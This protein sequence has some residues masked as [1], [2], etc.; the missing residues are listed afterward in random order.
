M[1]L[2]V[3]GVINLDS[4]T[5]ATPTDSLGN[6]FLDCGA[7]KVLF[8]SSAAALQLFY[9]L[10]TGD[11]SGDVISV[12]NPAGNH[13]IVQAREFLN[14]A[15]SSPVDVTASIANAS[16]GSGNPNMAVGPITPTADL[17]VI[18]GFCG[19][20]F[21]LGFLQHGAYFIGGSV[22]NYMEYTILPVA[23]GITADWAFSSS[24]IPYGAIVAAFKSASG[25]AIPG[26]GYGAG[27]GAN[28]PPIPG[29]IWSWA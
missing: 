1:S 11:I 19:L 29:K 13:L 20:H 15:P 14:M 3:A 24:A 25:A 4:T 17:D 5:I 7:G 10:N 18:V 23:E 26:I 22:F 9:A 27:G 12:A 21:S 28:R 16:T 6:V 8:N 2:L